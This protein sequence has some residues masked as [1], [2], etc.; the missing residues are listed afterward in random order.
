M[1]G[2]N[3]N[4]LYLC[5]IETH[6]FAYKQHVSIYWRSDRRHRCRRSANILISK[7]KYFLLRTDIV[8]YIS[9]VKNSYHIKYGL[10]TVY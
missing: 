4:L 7:F 6:Y 1:C 5:L 2:V 3:V 8:R 10:Q 9:Y